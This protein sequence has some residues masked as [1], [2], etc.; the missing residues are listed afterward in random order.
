MHVHIIIIIPA[1]T[2]AYWFVALGIHVS[3]ESRLPVTVRAQLFGALPDVGGLLTEPAVTDVE[4]GKAT[5][6]DSQL[7]L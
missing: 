5:T 4:P 6:S 2:T 1:A 7:F 3:P